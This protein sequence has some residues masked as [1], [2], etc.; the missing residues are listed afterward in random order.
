LSKARGFKK[1]EIKQS[2]KVSERILMINYFNFFL[3]MP[4]KIGENIL[5]KVF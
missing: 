4:K 2:K 3:F 5:K 1:T